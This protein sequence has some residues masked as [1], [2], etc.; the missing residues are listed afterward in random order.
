MPGIPASPNERALRKAKRSLKSKNGSKSACAVTSKPKRITV[1]NGKGTGRPTLKTPELCERICSEIAE[2]KTMTAVLA[3]PGMPSVQ[4]VWQ[5][6]QG[7]E[8]FLNALARARE[9][10]AVVMADQIIEITDSDLKTHE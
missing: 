10:G 8:S 5:W 1:P 7:D 6:R 4:D 2:G 9:Q 3:Q